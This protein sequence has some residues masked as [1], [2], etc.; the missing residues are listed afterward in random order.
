[1][2]GQIIKKGEKKWL[3]RIFTGRDGNGK[4]QYLNK[5]IHGNKKDA[6]D[7]LS[8][9]LTDISQGTFVAPSSTTLD[10]YL[11][12]MAQEFREAET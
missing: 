7:Y 11:N 9:T 5:L 6:S 2:A 10:E 4:R 3:V 1:M 8:R 12:G